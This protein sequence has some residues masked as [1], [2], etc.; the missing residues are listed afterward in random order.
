MRGL[1]LDFHAVEL[2]VAALRIPFVHALGLV[3]E[4]EHF[5]GSDGIA[6]HSGCA[7]HERGYQLVALASLSVINGELRIDGECPGIGSTL[8]LP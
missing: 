1:D 2:A 6:A 7:V 8:L 4:V 5:V 3:G